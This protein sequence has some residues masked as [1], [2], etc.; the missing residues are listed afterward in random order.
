[1]AILLNFLFYQAVWWTAIWG[2]ANDQ[3]YLG[4]VALAVFVGIHFTRSSNRGRDL[5]L[6]LSVTVVGGLVDSG[7]ASQNVYAFHSSGPWGSALPLWMWGLWANY[8][9]T[10]FGALGWMRSRLFF[11]GVLGAVF[12]PLT[13]RGAVSLGALELPRETYS[14]IA[15][16]VAWALLLPGTL[17]IANACGSEDAG[18]EGGLPP[19]P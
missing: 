8:S 10:L 5:K 3:P 7:L 14:L 19:G 13:Y 17:A 1:M 4:L 9:M 18:P 11:A 6:L 12:G 15:L 2:A 16:S